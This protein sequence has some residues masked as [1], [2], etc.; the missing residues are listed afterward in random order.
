MDDYS[1]SS[2][3]E[4][5]NEWCA[6][7]VSILTHSIIQGVNSIF[8]ESMKLCQDN[9]EHNKYLMTFQNLLSRIPQWNPSTIELE[10]QRIEAVSGCKYLED[11]VTCVHIIQLKALTCIRVGQKQKKIDIDV[12]SIDKFIHQVYIN[13]ARKLYTNIYLFEKDIYPLQLQKNNRELEV[14]VKEAILNTIRE[15]VPVEQILRA[16]M[17]E[18]EE[19]EVITEP[20]VDEE[21]VAV[22][23][24]EDDNST[25]VAP[26]TATDENDS[27]A[28]DADAAELDDQNENV[29]VDNK[30]DMLANQV[31]KTIDEKPSTEEV[32]IDFSDVDSVFNEDG[33]KK[34][35]DA[36]KDLETLDKIAVI[37]NEKRAMEN[38]EDERE[39]IKLNI[40]DDVQIHMDA[41]N[42]SNSI[43][44]DDSPILD[45][46]EIL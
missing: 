27:V 30:L 14:L 6:R 42:L 31:V 39:N 36:P 21:S 18:T 41:I 19:H 20:I 32:S 28:V 35:V 22:A 44:L 26:I 10:R 2:L 9:G 8:N 40:G 38:E 33:T 5:K 46:I 1:I 17:E 12:P 23:A 4:S 29:S 16:Y 15:N 25:E 11:L 43:D 34:H 37:N 45:D 13:T 7:L 24:A 3:T